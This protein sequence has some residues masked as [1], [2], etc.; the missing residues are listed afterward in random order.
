MRVMGFFAMVAHTEP[1]P[2]LISPPDPGM[3][4][5]MSASLWPVFTLTRVMVP[6][7]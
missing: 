3:L 6:S 7:P 1:K 5:A 2:K 4:A